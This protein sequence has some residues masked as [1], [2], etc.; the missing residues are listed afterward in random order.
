M[1]RPAGLVLALLLAASSLSC[2][3]Y[4]PFRFQLAPRLA[5]EATRLHGTAPGPIALRW[6]PASFPSRV[7]VQGAS[8]FIGGA[9]RTQIPTG[10]SISTKVREF[11]AAAVGLE[12]SAG[13][14]VTIHVVEAKTSFEFGGRKQGG[15]DRA[16]CSLK[17]EVD[18]GSVRWSEAYFA[19]D[20]TGGQ[21]PTV[22]GVLD[23]V[24]D[25]VSAALARDVVR[26]LAA[27]HP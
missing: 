4:L 1:R 25:E 19:S 3:L 15:I 24:Y 17:V 2:K 9:S 5:E 14:I 21:P 7:D 26:R 27:T 13:R 6:D 12:E 20:E 22:T 10:I 8:G 23:G 18:D 16:R 11:L